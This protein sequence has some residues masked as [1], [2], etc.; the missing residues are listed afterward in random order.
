VSQPL[1]Q[2]LAT[3]CLVQASLLLPLPLLLGSQGG[4]L[5]LVLLLVCR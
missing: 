2:L 1:R 3:C 4:A 5:L